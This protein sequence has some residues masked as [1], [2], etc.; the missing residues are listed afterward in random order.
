M[1]FLFD[2][3][4]VILFFIA[5]KWG[6][7]H[8]E[9]L[10]AWFGNTPQAPIMLATAAAILASVLQIFWLKL[11]HGKVDKM[12]WINLGLIGFFGG[13]TLLLRD[14][15]FIK[16]KPTVLYWLLSGGMATALLFH[17]NA[18]RLMLQ[19]KFSLPDTVWQR[20]NG[21]WILFFALMGVL[22]LW[23]AFTFSTDTWVD[24]KLFGATALIFV[25][26]LAQGLWLSRHLPDTEEA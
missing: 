15:T 1:K 18:M 17:K 24:F 3:F 12:P 6:K 13:L 9:M 7:A 23:V 25:F 2:L 8:P 11:R 16:W 22:N 10:G 14:E 19:N 26:A 4:P 21:A 5:F 20:M